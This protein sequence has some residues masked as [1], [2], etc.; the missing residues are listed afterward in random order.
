MLRDLAV[1]LLDLTIGTGEHCDERLVAPAK[2]MITQLRAAATPADF[3][4]LLPAVQELRRLIERAQGAQRDTLRGLLSLLHLIVENI[5]ELVP[6]G[7]WIKGQIEK[8]RSMLAE[9]VDSQSLA[10]AEKAFLDVIARQGAI[11]KRLD[12]AKAALKDMLSSFI[13]RLGAMCD[14]TGDYQNKIQDYAEQIENADDIA[15]LPGILKEL[16]GDTR[17]VQ[18]DMVR[19]RNDLLQARQRATAYEHQI[20]NLERELADISS[21]LKADQL[22]GVLNRRGLNEAFEVESARSD[23]SGEPLSVALL[24]VD[25]FKSLN[26]T[27]GHAVGDRA[28][29]HLAEVV[30]KTVRPTDVVARYGG[31][32]F[33]VVL[34]NTGRS[35]AADIMARVQRQLTRVFFLQH[36]E[37]LLITFSAGVTQRQPGEGQPEVLTRAD[38]ALYLAKGSGKNK[39]VCI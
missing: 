29:Q 6:D 32:E 18:A 20:S 34:P 16:L 30:R 33:V 14:S 5:E 2:G 13:Q 31:E 37:R 24:D 36:N 26:D 1:E 21:L 17:Q 39:V 7:R 10:E 22:T 15:Q 11:R 27:H 9:P 19:T 12:E 25:N 4:R 35:E 3:A 38:R 8:I 28:L 23:R